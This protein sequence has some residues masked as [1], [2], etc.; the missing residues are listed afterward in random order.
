MSSPIF[1]LGCP[2]S[3][4]TMMA[5]IL[6]KHPEMFIFFERGIFTVLLKEWQRHQKKYPSETPKEAFS[7]SVVKAWKN[8]IE[9]RT[10]LR[11]G[12]SQVLHCIKDTDGSYK[13]MV[14]AL[15]TMLA[16]RVKDG[17]IR[18]GDKTPHH[19][20]SIEQIF[21]KYPQARV[22]YVK[23]NPYHIVSSLSKK[24]FYPASDDPL[25]NAEVVYQYLNTYDNQRR[26]V[27]KS[28]ILEVRKE[29]VVNNTEKKVKKICSFL[30]VKYRKKLLKKGGKRVKKASGWPEYKGW[31]KIKSK[32]TKN[33]RSLPPEVIAYLEDAAQRMG[34]DNVKK[35]G[36]LKVKS[37]IKAY[38]YRILNN[39]MR[40]IYRTRNPGVKAFFNL[41]KLSLERVKKWYKKKR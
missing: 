14:D 16:G 8:W 36:F 37:S 24:E 35:N 25:F 1:V 11:L 13:S 18:W 40:K 28:K 34:Y 4:N 33:K 20:G 23:R 10:S 7:R 29:E 2:R 22:I 27:D 6:C 9:E 19:V 39:I 21:N 3:G 26:K 17:Q 30:D 41:R 15:M 38:N 12:S 5:C 31:K 32:N